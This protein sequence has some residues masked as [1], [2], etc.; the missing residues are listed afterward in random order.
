[1]PRTARVPFDPHYDSCE[2]G[3]V[4]APILLVS[5]LTHEV[6]SVSFFPESDAGPRLERKQAMNRGNSRQ[7]QEE[8]SRNGLITAAG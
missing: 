7:H 3:T 5:K 6:I 4:I 2:P 1:M 8:E